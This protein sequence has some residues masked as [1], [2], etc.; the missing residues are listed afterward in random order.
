[1]YICNMHLYDISLVVEMTDEWMDQILIRFFSHQNVFIPR[2]QNIVTF[3][4][5]PSNF[6]LRYSRQFVKSFY[7]DGI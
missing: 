4:V 5:E 6:E 1:M 3:L 2:Q 7:K